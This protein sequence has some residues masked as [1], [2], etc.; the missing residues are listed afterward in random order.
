[1]HHPQE[2]S[3]HEQERI[4]QAERVWNAFLAKVQFLHQALEEERR[5]TMDRAW[6]YRICADEVWK[7]VV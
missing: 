5:N 6:A 7:A 2:S 4:N 3:S 1:M